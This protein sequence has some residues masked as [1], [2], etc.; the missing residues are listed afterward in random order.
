[1]S[2]AAESSP[3]GIWD[4]TAVSDGENGQVIS[5]KYVDDLAI[6]ETYRVSN[7]EVRPLNYTARNV[8]HA[9]VGLLFGALFSWGVR[10]IAQRFRTAEGS[11]WRS[12]I[13]SNHSENR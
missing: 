2:R 7:G 8:G 6:S 11:A 5:V 10:K 12:S 3:D 9:F 4:Y 1:M 13:A